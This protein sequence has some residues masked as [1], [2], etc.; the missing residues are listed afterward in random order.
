V[1]LAQHAVASPRTIGINGVAL[2]FAI[3]I[4]LGAAL[5]SLPAA[6]APGYEWHFLDTL[7]TATSAVCVVGLVVVDTAGHWSTFG[8]GVIL[9]MIQLGGLGVMIASVFILIVLRRPISFRDRFE[10]SEISRAGGIRSVAGFIWATVLLTILFELLG[11]AALWYRLRG[12]HGED[13]ALWKG[14]FYSV[15][16]FNNAGFDLVPRFVGMAAYNRDPVVLMIMALLVVFGGLGALVLMDLLSKRS[17]KALSQHSRLVLVASAGLLALGFFG[18]LVTEFSNPATMGRMDLADK[19]V[20]ALFHSVISRTAGFDS[21]HVSGFRDETQFLVMALMY[22]GGATG[23]TAGGIKV[24]TLAVLVLAM[25][26]AVQGYEHAS[27]FGA[28][29]PHRLVYRALSVAT[30]ALL[31]IFVATLVLTITEAFRFSQVLFEV[32]SAF[33]TVGLST[34]ITPDLSVVGKATI[35]VVMYLGRLGPLTL[36]Y[37]LAQ[38]AREPS[39][40]LPEREIGIG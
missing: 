9:A 11:A 28:R 18:I 24:T 21:L 26:A 23:S 29:F 31:V 14:L 4:L 2:G 19:V 34:G 17:W 27:G 39:Y 13:D 22:I 3:L 32:V 7:F 5:L 1:D 20:N 35:I 40:S 37:A 30:L 16:A 25:V 38:R 8:Q 12:A 10:I 15:S 36:V 33:A 6:R